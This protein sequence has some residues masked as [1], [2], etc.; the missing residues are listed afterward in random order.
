MMH[1]VYALLCTAWLA[2]L[3]EYAMTYA[4]ENSAIKLYSMQELLVDIEP[5]KMEIDLI[6][7][8]SIVKHIVHE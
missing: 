1:I 3:H 7:Y 8:L 4:L 5:P 6:K 2:Y